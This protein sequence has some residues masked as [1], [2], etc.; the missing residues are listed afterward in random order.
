LCINRQL[1]RH[2]IDGTPSSAVGSIEFQIFRRDPEAKKDKKHR[3]SS[4]DTDNEDETSSSSSEES[5]DTES[6]GDAQRAPTYEEYT[7]WWKLNSLVGETGKPS[8]PFE[9]GLVNQKTVTPTAKARVLKKWSGDFKLWASFKFVLLSSAE[10][11]KLGFNTSKSSHDTPRKIAQ[12]SSKDSGAGKSSPS[13]AKEWIND[14]DHEDDQSLIL[15]TSEDDAVGPKEEKAKGKEI[16]GH[17]L[18][19]T[20]ES[21]ENQ[22]LRADTSQSK[23]KTNSLTEENLQILDSSDEEIGH[24]DVAIKATATPVLSVRG[25]HE[26]PITNAQGSNANDTVPEFPPKKP[27]SKTTKAKSV[28]EL[29]SA[30]TGAFAH[31]QRKDKPTSDSGIL[32][33]PA[34]KIPSDQTRGELP[35]SHPG[36]GSLLKLMT[37]GLQEDQDLSSSSKSKLEFVVAQVS[38]NEEPREERHVTPEFEL[39]GPQW[40]LLTPPQTARLQELEKFSA[41]NQPDQRTPS[42]TMHNGSPCPTHNQHPGYD[43]FNNSN[44]LAAM[45]N[46]IRDPGAAENKCEIS[47]DYHIQN[48]SLGGNLVIAHQNQMDIQN[49]LF[50][51][52]P[53]NVKF[54]DYIR[55]A[56]GDDEQMVDAPILQSNSVMNMEI[57]GPNS[58]SYSTLKK[59]PV[60]FNASPRGS[61]SSLEPKVIA[62]ATHGTTSTRTPLPGSRPNHSL[63]MKSPTDKSSGV[64]PTHVQNLKNEVVAPQVVSSEVTSSKKTAAPAKPTKKEGKTSTPTKNTAMKANKASS[65]VPTNTQADSAQAKPKKAAAP[66]TTKTPK[67]PKAATGTDA[68]PSASHTKPKPKGKGKGKAESSPTAAEKRKAGQMTSASNEDG[69]NKTN[70]SPASKQ[71]AIVERETAA[72]EARIQA[73]AEK[74]KLL[75]QHLQ[76]MKDAKVQREKVSR[77]SYMV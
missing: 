1:A 69:S 44:N 21:R 9:V 71:I 72:A 59:V 47:G 19:A 4:S 41:F 18:Q 54:N 29:I 42:G 34:K 8:P 58:P 2:Y 53:P 64:Q 66:K 3:S 46:M 51:Q 77:Y 38:N 12:S 65:T 7:D 17:G 63:S 39:R 23:P 30:D 11:Q 76:A 68:E 27:V 43:T 55:D 26:V 52:D 73:A 57:D 35:S 15:S 37:A 40:E 60:T 67:S 5:I 16:A 61:E 31:L 36:T 10:L 56:D 50:I 24:E 22:L 13:T 14:S 48:S 74:K 20:P 70:Q 62:E 32:S 45:P 33:G 49:A 75:E 25:S 28:Q 6:V